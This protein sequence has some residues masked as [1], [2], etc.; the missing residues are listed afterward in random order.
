MNNAYNK[1]KGKGKRLVQ[2]AKEKIPGRMFND[3]PED[4]GPRFRPTVPTAVNPRRPRPD[5]PAQSSS[6]SSEQAQYPLMPGFSTPDR[7]MSR[8]PVD[9]NPNAQGTATQAPALPL[10][11]SPSLQSGPPNLGAPTSSQRPDVPTPL[12]GTDSSKTAISN[13]NA[14]AALEGRAPSRPASQE[15]QIGPD[16]QAMIQADPGNRRG[17]KVLGQP[18]GP[19]GFSQ[20][21]S[22]PS[23]PASSEL[24]VVGTS[25]VSSTPPPA[26]TSSTAPPAPP[27]IS[28][29]RPKSEIHSNEDAMNSLMGHVPKEEPDGRI[30]FEGEKWDAKMFREEEAKF[31][32][33]K[34]S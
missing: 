10:R 19:D 8:T 13:P 24:P 30:A 9:T 32:A 14:L 4:P 29:V 31:N 3:D 1:A 22:A 6:L 34:R 7:F 5:Q 27:G 21:P 18:Q 11:P 23:R 12:A 17:A 26:A 2:Q 25:R 16:A 20:T 28:V 15:T 33:G